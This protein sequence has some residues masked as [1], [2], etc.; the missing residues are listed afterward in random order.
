MGRAPTEHVTPDVAK[1]LCLRTGS[2]AILAGSVSSLG[3]QYVVG[4]EAD[5]CSTGDTLAKEQAE[6]VGKEGV[7]KALDTAAASLRSKM[8]ESLASVQKFDVPIEA[9]TPSLEALKAY[10]MG[11]TTGRT[12]G[13]AEAIPFMKRAIELDPNFA[14][15]Y[16]GIAVEYSNLGRADLAAANARKAYELRDRVSEREQYRISAFYFQYVTG[17]VEKATEAYEL[18][19][20]SYPRDPV[21]HGNLGYIYSALGQYD[22]SI[23]ETEA[24]QHLEPSIVGYGNLAGTYINL[25]RLKEARQTLAEAQ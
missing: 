21:P 2:K 12:K 19:A 9:T 25:N 6:A 20:K 4:L 8:G 5:A 13:D 23:V 11:I 10:S 14:M 22:K 24:Q 15:A 1:E 7:L 18:W 16:T 17:E 3:T